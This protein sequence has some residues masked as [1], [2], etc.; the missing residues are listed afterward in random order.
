MDVFGLLET[1]GSKDVIVG[2]IMSFNSSKGGTKV[3]GEIPK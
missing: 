3:G 2:D 1:T